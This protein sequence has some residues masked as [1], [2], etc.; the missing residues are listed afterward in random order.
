VSHA[1]LTAGAD[2]AT[3]PVPSGTLVEVGPPATVVE[4]D[5]V[6]TFFEELPWV[7]V[8][9]AKPI[10]IATTAATITPRRTR[11]RRC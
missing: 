6:L 2:L 5:E 3:S 10:A 1:A 9:T 11:L 4:G 8:Y 7:P